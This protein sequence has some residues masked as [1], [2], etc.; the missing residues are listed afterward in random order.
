[1]GIDTNSTHAEVAF[2]LKYGRVE[3]MYVVSPY[4]GRERNSRPCASCTSVM[5]SFK[6]KYVVYSTGDADTP[7]RRE[8]VADMKSDYI[9]SGD[10]NSI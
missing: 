10:V 6:V 2:L 4:K 3:T 5:K 8:L 1:L 9:S 7:Y